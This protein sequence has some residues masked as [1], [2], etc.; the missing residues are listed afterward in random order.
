MAAHGGKRPGAG[1]P[2][3]SKDKVTTDI[4]AAAQEHGPA[5][6]ALLARLLNDSPSKTLRFKAAVELLDRG[7]GKPRQSSDV[8]LNMT[9][10]PS[11]YLIFDDGLGDESRPARA[12]PP[13]PPAP[14][15]AD[16]QST[17]RQALWNHPL[18]KIQQFQQS[19]LNDG[20]SESGLS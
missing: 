18:A 13:P 20:I 16:R 5:A 9:G 7:F 1:R 10:P 17:M 4:R 3:G 11:V 12:T 6:V 19:E 8:D 15:L 2:K 14:P